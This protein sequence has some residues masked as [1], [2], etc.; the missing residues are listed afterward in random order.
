MTIFKEQTNK[1][2]FRQFS[3]KLKFHQKKKKFFL[4]I[5]LMNHLIKKNHLSKKGFLKVHLTWVHH[6][7]FIKEKKE[8]SS[9]YL[10]DHRMWTHNVCVRHYTDHCFRFLWF[11]DVP[12]TVNCCFQKNVLEHNSQYAIWYRN[13]KMG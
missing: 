10:S 5:S 13:E 3:K 12:G 1:I 9:H 6:F 11:F 7:F 8:S 4:R 2:K